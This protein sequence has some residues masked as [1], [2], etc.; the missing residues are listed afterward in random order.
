LS[1]IQKLNF[2]KKYFIIIYDLFSYKLTQMSFS[3][4]SDE[5]NA[6]AQH[7]ESNKFPS[8]RKILEDIA[9][10]KG[11][12]NAILKLALAI[13]GAPKAGP[14]PKTVEEC[15]DSNY[16]DLKAIYE[17]AFHPVVTRTKGQAIA[18]R[19]EA[20]EPGSGI[21]M[22]QSLYYVLCDYGFTRTGRHLSGS[23]RVLL[24]SRWDGVN[25]P[26]EVWLH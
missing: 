3:S 18:D 24:S 19:A 14:Y 4:T 21:A 25:T 11:P 22:L 23:A 8:L 5:Q 9:N 2:C 16:Q 26:T 15:D 13:M 17:S 12:E 6:I 10:S 7:V 1:K 20:R